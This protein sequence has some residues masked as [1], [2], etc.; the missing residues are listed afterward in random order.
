MAEVLDIGTRFI[1]MGKFR[2]IKGSQSVDVLYKLLPLLVRVAFLRART[3][4]SQVWALH[5]QS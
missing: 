1:L 2:Y 5:I 4:K 3:Q